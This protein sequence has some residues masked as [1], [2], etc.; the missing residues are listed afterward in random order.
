MVKNVSELERDIQ[1]VHPNMAGAGEKTE[2]VNNRDKRSLG[3]LFLAARLVVSAGMFLLSAL[4]P[5]S[6]RVS[7]CIYII[8]FLMAGLD[9]IIKAVTGIV[10]LNVFDKSVITIAAC[11][12]ALVTGH[13]YE[14]AAILILSRLGDLLPLRV[15]AIYRRAIRKLLISVPETVLIL[16]DSRLIAVPLRQV[17]PGSIVLL[18]PNKPVLID[19]IILSGET[20]MDTSAI[21]GE[22]A[23]VKLSPGDTVLSGYY[24]I[25]I[26]VMV[27]ATASFSRSAATRLLDYTEKEGQFGSGAKT[28]PCLLRFFKVYTPVAT[29]AVVAF[30][31][32]QFVTYIGSFADWIHR[33]LLLLSLL[34]PCAVLISVPLTAHMAVAGALK[35]GI[36]FKD[37]LSVIKLNKT[38]TFIFDK[39]GSLTTGKYKVVSIEPEGIE[40]Q[41]LVI[42]AAHALAFSNYPH[43]SAVIDA[44]DGQINRSLISGFRNYNGTGISIM[45]KGIEISCGNTVFMDRLSIPTGDDSED[46]CVIHVAAAGKYA[47]RILLSDTVK[48][49]AP[50]AIFQLQKLG[51]RR[52]VM[53]SEDKAYSTRRLAIALGIK[54]F[55][56][57]CL[58]EEKLSL[59]EA[60]KKEG[61]KN[62]PT[63]FVGNGIGNGPALM[64]S[65]MGICVGSAGTDSAIEASDVHILHDS[66]LMVAQA[67][68]IAAATGRIIRMNIF[69]SVCGKILAAALCLTGY[70]PLWGGLALEAALAAITALNAL[71]AGK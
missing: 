52:I 53:L 31:L 39:T 3:G 38:K 35:K 60:A 51:A 58:P 43:A 57:E 63:A 14:C 32:L 33:S 20:S 9:I 48:E 2:S 45:V 19:G 54:E 30:F 70:I 25:S 13:T 24:N 15:R 11:C 50:S 67:A 12:G 27:K 1:V 36:I 22:T 49:D 7:I 56:S 55:H 6:E 17:A 46:E 47:G 59:L 18:E 66:P 64:Q 34:C 10:S 41:A 68:L 29:G 21:T 28:A 26:P 4:L 71:R 69:L 40:P 42:M 44:F 8:A 16:R 61:S 37:P 23:P 65:D 62:N 5:L